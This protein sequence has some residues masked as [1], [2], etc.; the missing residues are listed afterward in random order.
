MSTRVNPALLPE[1]EKYGAVN[2]SACFNCGNCTAICPL[3]TG[4]ESF[5]RRMIRYA[6][7]GMEE[8]LLGSK[9]LWQCY[10][11]AECSKTCPRQAEPGEF[12]AAARRYAIAKYDVTGLAGRMFKSA[13]VNVAAVVGMAIFFAVY[14]LS[15]NQGENYKQLSLWKFIPEIYVRSLGIAVFIIV[16]L[17]GLLGVIRMIRKISRAGGLAF[18]S[19]IP[20]GALNWWQAFKET[21]FVQVFGQKNYREEECEE[22]DRTPLLLRKWF[23]HAAIMYGF[24]GLFAATAL[25]FLFKPVG[26]WVPIYSP[27][28]LLGTVSGLAL[29]YGTSLAFYKRLQK[30]DKYTRSSEPADWILLALLWL[31]GLTGFLLEI[32]NYAPA[33]AT[34]GY[35]ML[36]VHVSLAMDLIVMLP[37]TK[38]AHVFYRTLALFLYALKPSPERVTG[39]PL[40]QE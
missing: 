40:V 14:L 29:L 5:P 36:I 34:W 10:Y 35:P 27:I 6:Q 19:P 15:F 2:I 33:P 12:M 32:A 24:L 11:C 22:I 9:E 16:G 26:S 39:R 37:F 25:D 3:S 1:I 7:V 30:R 8:E 21:L 28:R 4:E 20:W 23:V 17:V 31:V 18:S 13:W 38:F